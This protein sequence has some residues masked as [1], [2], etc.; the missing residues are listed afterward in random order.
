MGHPAC[1]T[2]DDGRVLEVV[3]CASFQA[4][5]LAAEAAGSRPWEAAIGLPALLCRPSLLALRPQPCTCTPGAPCLA[6]DRGWLRKK[7]SLTAPPDMRAVLR[8][9]REVADA[10]AFLHS[11]DVLH[12]DLTGGPPRRA[13]SKG[14]AS[15]GG[16]AG[17]RREGGS[18][19][20]S[21][22]KQACIRSTGAWKAHTLSLP[23][24]AVPA[25][26]G[27]PPLPTLRRRALQATTFCLRRLSL[28][29]RTVEASAPG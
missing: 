3:S 20:A 23:P 7:R 22:S 16:C 29:Q 10:M 13:G 14:R 15:A 21:P 19:Q 17:F 12:C 8:T 24:S 26:K 4:V 28:Q 5:A 9:L 6:A 1:C 18:R 2:Q 11:H 25:S 27:A